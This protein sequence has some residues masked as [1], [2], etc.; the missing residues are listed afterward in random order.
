LLEP[1]DEMTTLIAP[2]LESKDDRERWASIIALGRHRYEPAFPLLQQL[3]LENIFAYQN[4]S[5]FDDPLYEWQLYRR[6]SIAFLLGAWE[7]P[8]AAVVLRQAFV[9]CWDIEQQVDL[10]VEPGR[11][12]NHEQWWH[13]FEDCLAYALGA[14]GAWGAISTLGLPPLHLRVATIF[15]ALGSLH[16]NTQKLFWQEPEWASSI[17]NEARYSPAMLAT[18]P[19][20]PLFVKP[21]TVA[22]SCKN[23]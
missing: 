11:V 14:L 12:Y 23:G 7:R 22:S 5:H 8:Q 2:L 6:C 3:L 19:D 18:Y 9:A 20:P 4:G 21:E 17:F 15:L 10:S 16:L 1:S 13:F